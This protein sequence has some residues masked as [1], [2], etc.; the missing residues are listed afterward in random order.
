[1]ALNNPALQETTFGE[2]SP[3]STI[4]PLKEH[5]TAQCRSA[6]PHVALRKQHAWLTCSIE[7]RIAQCRFVIAQAAHSIHLVPLRQ[8]ALGSPIHHSNVS[9]ICSSPPSTWYLST[10][11]PPS[12]ITICSSS[13]LA[14]SSK[15]CFSCS[16]TP[17]HT[18]F[19]IALTR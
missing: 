18:S 11:E 14:I 7:H 10:R 1:M 12:T 8:Y 17:T 13:Y 5:H 15:I 2:G 3:L 4:M 6:M 9:T 16:H 19:T